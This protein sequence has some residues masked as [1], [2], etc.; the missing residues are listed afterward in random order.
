MLGIVVSLLS[1][2]LFVLL[3]GRR[4]FLGPEGEGVFTLFAALFLLVGLVLFGIG[5]LGEYVGRIYQ[6]VRA[7]P[8]YVIDAIL[9]RKP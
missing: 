4:L 8:R 3:A 7:R 6:E 1:G 2:G 9:E 5:L